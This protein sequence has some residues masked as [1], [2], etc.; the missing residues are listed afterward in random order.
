MSKN[1]KGKTA[2]CIELLQILNTGRT[3]NIAELAEILEVNPR[4][5]PEY[6]KELREV[7]IGSIYDSWSDMWH[8]FGQ[9]LYHV[10]N[11]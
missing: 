6:I 5:I 10:F 7:S 1:Y 9:N 2:C 8:E 11:D 3:Y 4:N